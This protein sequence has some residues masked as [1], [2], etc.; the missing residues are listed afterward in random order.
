MGCC[1]GKIASVAKGYSILVIEYIFKMPTV[2]SSQR[3][4]RKIYCRKCDKATWINIAELIEYFKKYGLLF[5]KNL[6]EL[7]NIPALPI[8]QKINNNDRFFCSVCKCYIPAK[9]VVE[10]EKCPL[11]K[12]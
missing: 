6:S 9:T 10:T 2:R 11:G 3:E 7:E 8:R 4:T 1:L 12:W 5:M